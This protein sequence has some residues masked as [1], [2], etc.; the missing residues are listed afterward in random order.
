[1]GLINERWSKYKQS[2]LIERFFQE[3]ILT[4]MKRFITKSSKVDFHSMRRK[5]TQERQQE[6]IH[7]KLPPDT[8]KAKL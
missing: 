8:I 6:R 7:V 5:Q 4:T 3:P 1:M 2:G